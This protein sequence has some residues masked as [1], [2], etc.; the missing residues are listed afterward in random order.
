MITSLR[1]ASRFGTAQGCAKDGHRGVQT[2]TSSVGRLSLTKVL[3]QAQQVAIARRTPHSATCSVTHL[4]IRDQATADL[5]KLAAAA[6]SETQL[7]L[8]KLEL[9]AEH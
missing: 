3:D 1:N 9:T 4:A 8:S 6:L 2:E 5:A 7:V